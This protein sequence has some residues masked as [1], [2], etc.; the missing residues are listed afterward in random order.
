M[1]VQRQ[2][3]QH[4]TPVVNYQGAWYIPVCVHLLDYRVLFN[5][6]ANINRKGCFYGTCQIA[7]IWVFFLC[8]WCWSSKV[9]TTPDYIG[10]QICC[11]LTFTG[12]PQ[13]HSNC[14]LVNSVM[15]IRVAPRS[16]ICLE[17]AFHS[18]KEVTLSNSL[19][20]IYHVY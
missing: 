10:A 11:A 20:Y 9:Y 15:F 5:I 14:V 12:V 8:K 19:A 6:F 17:L 3:A 4:L 13:L 16:L 18:P 1:Y 2:L 7:N